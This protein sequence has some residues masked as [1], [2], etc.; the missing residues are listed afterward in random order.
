MRG[1]K[2][3]LR[4]VLGVAAITQE[5]P[6]ERRHRGAMLAVERLRGV[7]AAVAFPCGLRHGDGGIYV[8]V[9]ASD[10]L[11]R[12]SHPEFSCRDAAASAR[13]RSCP[14]KRSRRWERTSKGRSTT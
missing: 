9:G 13:L 8:R 6:A 1:E 2:D 12:L 7:R 10:S 14:S 4:R 3:L 11:R 5:R